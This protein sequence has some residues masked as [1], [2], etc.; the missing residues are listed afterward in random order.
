MKFD[1]G[2]RKDFKSETAYLKDVFRRNREVITKVYKEDAESKFIDAVQSIKEV[3]EV[4]IR[5]ALNTL[6]QAKA[7][8]PYK[9]TAKS[10]AIQA[11]INFDKYQ[12]FRNLTRDEKGRFTRVDMDK[13]DWD[14][15]SESYIYDNRVMISFSNSPLGVTLSLI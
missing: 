12:E 9:E 10:N 7:F 14:E 15:D 1:M 3:K 6:S 4:N 8:T 2:R 5:Q 13:L 11:V